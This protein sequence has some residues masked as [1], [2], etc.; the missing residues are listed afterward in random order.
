MTRLVLRQHFL[1]PLGYNQGSR[2]PKADQ[3]RLHPDTCV[4]LG[5]Y[6][7]HPWGGGSNGAAPRGRRSRPDKQVT[8]FRGSQWPIRYNQGS[9]WRTAGRTGTCVDLGSHRRNP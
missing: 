9:P 1:T 2:R 8:F 5:S 6:R 3:A 4:D 7:R